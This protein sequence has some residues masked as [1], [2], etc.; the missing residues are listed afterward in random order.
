MTHPQELPWEAIQFY[1]TAPFPCSYI[2]AREARSQVAT[3][4]DRVRADVYSDLITKGFRRSGLFAYR[5]HCDA[6]QSC[7]SVRIP[8]A[9]FRPST[10][11]R[12]A[13][14]RLGHLQTRMMSPVFD[15]AHFELYQQ[16]QNARHSGGGMDEDDPQ[17]YRQ[18]LLASHVNTRLVEFWEPSDAGPAQLVMVSIVDVVSD[19]LSA[20]YTFFNPE[21]KHSL[22]TYGILWQIEQAKRLGLDYVYLGYWIAESP[23]MAYKSHFLPQERLIQGHWVPHGPLFDRSKVSQAGN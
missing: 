11:Q 20:V 16:Y 10:Q 17:Q 1:S 9:R 12:R 13:A 5:P 23:K 21:H 6:C 19:G 3:P 8:V 14:K 22:G 4:S 18:F 15:F 7:V 2:D